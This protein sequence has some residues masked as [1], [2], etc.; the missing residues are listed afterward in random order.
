[1]FFPDRAIGGGGSPAFG[2][3]LPVNRLFEGYFPECQ[4]ISEK[5]LTPGQT[6]LGFR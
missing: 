4:L 6:D 2:G 5:N 3:C 1:M